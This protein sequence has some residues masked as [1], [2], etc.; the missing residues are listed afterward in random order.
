MTKVLFHR[1]TGNACIFEDDASLEDWSDFQETPLPKEVTRESVDRKRASSLKITDWMARSDLTMSQSQ[2][3]YRQALRDITDQTAY[4]EGR[5]GDI[6]WPT[7]P[8]DVR[9]G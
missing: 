5:Y 9:V 3:D 4:T 2:I 8:D 7:R 6:V 1:Q